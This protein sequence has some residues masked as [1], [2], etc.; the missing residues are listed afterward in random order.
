MRIDKYFVGLSTN[1]KGLSDKEIYDIE[2]TMGIT[3][4]NDYKEFLRTING[5]EGLFNGKNY[6][7]LWDG[8]DLEKYNREYQVEDFI[9]DI[10]FIGSD[11]GGEAFAF[12]KANGMTIIRVPF[13]GMERELVVKIA[14]SFTG[15]L[16]VLCTKALYE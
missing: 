7:I 4:P 2:K 14:S 5:C 1:D 6:A 16:E 8:R 10:L 11:G 9:N 12:D 15:F 3:F 13:V